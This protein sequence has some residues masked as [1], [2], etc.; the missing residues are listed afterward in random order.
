M[1][2]RIFLTAL[3][4]CLLS[5]AATAYGQQRLV[6]LTRYEGSRI[7]GVD[8]SSAF[9]VTLVPS[10][11]TKVVAELNEELEDRLRLTLGADGI[12]RCALEL[13]R[14]VRN[15]VLKLTVYLPELTY[16]QASGP[17]KIQGAG[18]FGGDEASLKM[19]EGASLRNFEFTGTQLKIDLTEVASVKAR[20]SASVVSLNVSQ[21]ANLEMDLTEN[22]FV[23]GNIRST[24]A[25]I[26]RGKTKSLAINMFNASFLRADNL[27]AEKVDIT[28]EAA[29]SATVHAVESLNAE[30]KLTAG[31][32][33]RGDPPLFNAKSSSAG[34]VKR[35]D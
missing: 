34:S 22:Q 13:T 30:A 16:L 31:I 35:I 21:A 18:P 10:D 1:K 11:Q 9:D 33:F 25:V 15:A 26:L 12:V 29:A 6:R 3:V 4:L 5:A 14:P 19:S 24:G 32:R 2:R 27:E 8:V 7:T 17:V 20:S 28:A 23:G